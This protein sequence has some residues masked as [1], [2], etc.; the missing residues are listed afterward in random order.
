MV[1][2]EEFD[3]GEGKRI[4]GKACWEGDARIQIP[5]DCHAVLKSVACVIC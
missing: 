3:K 1:D 5:G 2:L 4:Y